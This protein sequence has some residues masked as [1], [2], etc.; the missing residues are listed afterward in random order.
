M[1][2]IRINPNKKDCQKL[3]Y[4][5]FDKH[6][7]DNSTGFPEAHLLIYVFQLWKLL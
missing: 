5:L 3:V 6:Y 2:E 1:Y 4:N 7:I